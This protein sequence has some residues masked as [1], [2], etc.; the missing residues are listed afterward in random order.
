MK[1]K[2]KFTSYAFHDFIFNGFMLT[3]ISFKLDQSENTHM[4]LSKN[5]SVKLIF[6]KYLMFLDILHIRCPTY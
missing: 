2:N 1:I 6:L 4:Y 3:I 5:N